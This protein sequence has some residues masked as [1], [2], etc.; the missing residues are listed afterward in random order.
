[1][2][3]VIEVHTVHMQKNQMGL[4]LGKLAVFD[5]NTEKIVSYINDHSCGKVP[6]LWQLLET[7]LASPGEITQ[8][9]M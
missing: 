6:F 8:S 4:E 2:Y 7:V 3:T 5:Y 9:E 1:M